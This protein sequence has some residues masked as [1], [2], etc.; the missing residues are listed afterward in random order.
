MTPTMQDRLA[1]ARDG[2]IGSAGFENPPIDSQATFRVVMTALAEPGS[3]REIPRMRARAPGISPAM[4]ALVLTL[5]DFETK[6]WF[7]EGVTSQAASYARF[8]T[9]ALVVDVPAEAAFA[10]VTK[11]RTMPR[12]AAFA[13]GTLDY[14][15]RS[16]TIIVEVEHL[17]STGRYGLRGPGIAGER[18]LDVAPL[19]ATFVE[20]LSANRAA[21]PCGID[22]LFCCGSFVA[23]LPRSTRLQ[24]EKD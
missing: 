7:D 14:P 15:D 21:Y 6:V 17:A 11:A 5:A 9:G 24:C 13:Q 10:V 23:A 20:D 18:K 22:V 16:T 4:T 19:P 8:H 3:I 2:L 12:L 1:S